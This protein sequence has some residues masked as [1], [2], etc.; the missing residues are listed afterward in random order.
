MTHAGQQTPAGSLFHE[1]LIGG[2][3]LAARLVSTDARSRRI[4]ATVPPARRSRTPESGGDPLPLSIGA[5]IS[6]LPTVY[7]SCFLPYGLIHF[8]FNLLVLMDDKT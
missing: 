5:N 1:L 6:K 8:Y 4:C 7:E 2:V 3:T